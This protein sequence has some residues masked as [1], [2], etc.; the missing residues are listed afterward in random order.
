MTTYAPVPAFVDQRRH[1]RTL[2]LILGA[3]AALIAAVMMAKGYVPMRL[4]DP[5]TTVTLIEEQ[6]PPPEN[7]PPAQS[8]DHSTIDHPTTAV[9][10]PH[11]DIPDVDT[12]PMPLPDPGP[13][14]GPTGDTHVTP[15]LP[16]RTGPRFITRGTD[17]KPPYPASKLR[18]GEEAVLRLRIAID[19]RG[20]VVAVDP[21][22]PADPVFLAAARRHLMAR[23]RYQPATED[24][25]AVATSTVIT[26]RFEL[27]D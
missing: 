21:V 17:V 9:P 22:G 2:L 27:N 20:R 1:P 18:D 25:H 11:L 19:E 8:D 3:H 23:W 26:L 24:G 14:V 10:I 4:P 6:K 5:P 7:P 13:M 15:V 16:V 12:I